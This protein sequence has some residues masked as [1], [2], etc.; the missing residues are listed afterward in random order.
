MENENF[1][2]LSGDIDERAYFKTILD[3]MAE[4]S[5]QQPYAERRAFELS[6][7]SFDLEEEVQMAMEEIGAKEKDL[8]QLI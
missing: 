4:K 2:H 6:G 7:D 1:V 5:G 8:G 3:D